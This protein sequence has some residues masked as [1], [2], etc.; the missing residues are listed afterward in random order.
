MPINFKLLVLSIL[1][2]IPFLWEGLGLSQGYKISPYLYAILPMIL[3]VYAFL[4]KKKVLFPRLITI[5][6][7]LFLFFSFLSSLFFSVDKQI[8]IEYLLF[9]TS[10]FLIFV[11]INNFHEEG[12]KIFLILSILG[13]IIFVLVS[14]LTYFPQF[15]ELPI[16]NPKSEYQFIVSYY[17]KH[18]HLGDFAGLLTILSLSYFLRSSKLFLVP[19]IILLPFILFSFSRSAY[20]GLTITTL[21]LLI[22]V[23]K[24]IKPL[25]IIAFILTITSLFFIFSSEQVRTALDL[26]T[27][28]FPTKDLFVGRVGYFIQSL[29][30]FLDRPLF[31]IGLGNFGYAS[32][33]YLDRPDAWTD[34]SHNI[35]IEVL[36]ENGLLAFISFM[37]LIFSSLR[38]SIKK[39]SIYF[40]L[41]IYLLLNFQTDYSYRIYSFFMLFI[42]LLGII[43]QEHKKIKIPFLYGTLSLLLL[44]IVI[45]ISTSHLLFKSGSYS[46]SASLYPFNK[47]VYPLF[48][49]DL[50]TK[51]D[52]LK[53]DKMLKRYE[54]VAPYNLTTLQFIGKFYEDKKDKKSALKYYERTY[55]LNPYV[56]FSMIEKIYS[57]KKELRS[58]RETR[59]FLQNVLDNYNTLPYYPADIKNK[60]RQFC[61]EMGETKICEKAWWLQDFF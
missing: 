31:G 29:N 27:F 43:V 33:L 45:S 9:Y 46:L 47:E 12:K 57:L 11:F 40:I 50:Q 34:T 4:A 49:K 41:F 61:Q 53:A 21:L 36:V 1:F 38:K 20:I 52:E 22:A 25:P 60:I 8:S 5:F 16:L 58:Q 44:T 39:S 10:S 24:R 17:A 28:Y 14:A 48:I 37:L 32:R 13:G 15:R 54:W 26:N 6:F 18:N 42:I 19:V 7:L 30:S 56:N 23:E 2:I 35:F 55:E 51:G 59:F 3:F